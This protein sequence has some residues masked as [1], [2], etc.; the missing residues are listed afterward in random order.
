MTAAVKIAALEAKIA[1][2]QAK[3]VEL[4]EKGDVSEFTAKVGDKVVYLFGRGENV[5]EYEGYVLGIRTPAE[6]E[7]GGTIAKVITGEGYDAEVRGVFL[8]K[9]LRLAAHWSRVDPAPVAQVDEAG[10]PEADA[11]LDDVTEG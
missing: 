8:S 1:T 9:I 2:L 6:G 7:K 10:Q 3:I 4:R 5:Q 11:A